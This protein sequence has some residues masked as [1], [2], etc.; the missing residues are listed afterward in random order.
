M[1]NLFN[2]YPHFG[3]IKYKAV[4]SGSVKCKNCPPSS[5]LSVT[6]I[7]KF[8]NDDLVS[9]MSSPVKPIET[10]PEFPLRFPLLVG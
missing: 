6:A 7:D 10:F 9:S 8:S 5:F 4:P 3:L 2:D 1:E